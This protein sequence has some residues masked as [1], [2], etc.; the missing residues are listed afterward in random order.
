MGVSCH[1]PGRAWYVCVSGHV[2]RSHTNKHRLRPVLWLTS[3]T[4]AV[5]CWRKNSVT[6]VQR[7]CEAIAGRPNDTGAFGRQIRNDPALVVV[8]GKFLGNTQQ[9]AQVH[10]AAAGFSF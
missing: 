6:D 9:P 7:A 8:K 4:L 10:R 2:Q 3:T 1:G 5:I